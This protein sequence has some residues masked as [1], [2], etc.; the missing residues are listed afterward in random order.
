MLP[1]LIQ[2]VARCDIAIIGAGMAGASLAAEI[3]GD[4]NVLLIEAEA[5]PGYH[6]TGRSAAFWSETYGGPAV[7][8]LTSASGDWL[9]RSGFLG[10]R[11]ALHLAA[12]GGG[13]A[14]DRLAAEFAGRGIPL[15]RMGRASIASILPGIRRGFDDA[16]AEPSC[17]DIDVA[18]L[19][20][21]YLGAARRAGGRLICDAR[22]IGIE[23]A[24]PGWRL[25]TTG[26]QVEASVIVNSAGAWA[27]EI[28]ALAGAMPIAIT[29]YRRTVVQ[30]LVEPAA[31][32]ELPLVIDAAGRYYFKPEAG[33]RIWLSPHDETPAIASDIAPDDYDVALAID[34]LE[35][36]VDWKIVKREKAWAGLRSFSPDRAPVYG[37]DCQTS[38]FFWFAG[39]GGFGIQTA[40]AAAMI[41]AAILL[42]R[43]LPSAV[44]SIDIDRYGPSRF[45]T[46]YSGCFPNRRIT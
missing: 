2:P 33:G 43:E 12:P 42:A 9:R 46:K 8:P 36:V 39:Q 18:A 35:Q 27:T 7:Q 23:R 41:G 3:G 26:G 21:H 11:G 13:V 14:L 31:P 10:P 34:R 17:S 40:P 6:S 24:G 5:Q 15:E 19:H 22:V 32:A 29:P 37:P 20:A 30:L 28:A 38:G 16:L 44:S 45:Q 25:S 1:P 4:A